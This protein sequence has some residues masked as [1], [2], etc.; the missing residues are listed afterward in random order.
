MGRGGVGGVGAKKENRLS[1]FLFSP[2]V[3]S[4]TGIW[5]SI[6]YTSASRVSMHVSTVVSRREREHGS[7]R[8]ARKETPVTNRMG[9][10]TVNTKLRERRLMATT[11]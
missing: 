5:G 3:S 1:S 10:M 6:K 9:R 2:P 7:T 4:L 11:I 8:R